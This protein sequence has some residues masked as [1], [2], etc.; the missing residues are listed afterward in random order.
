MENETFD[1]SVNVLLPV[2][3][4]DGTEGIVCVNLICI[5]ALDIGK[6]DFERRMYEDLI[7]ERDIVLANICNVIK[8]KNE[9]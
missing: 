5:P 2:I 4:D 1:D 8:K 3:M 6:L 7:A 9:I